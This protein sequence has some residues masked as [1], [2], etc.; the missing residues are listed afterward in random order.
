MRVPRH[1]LGERVMELLL[2]VI[3]TD[4]QFEEQE[5]VEIELVVRQSSGGRRA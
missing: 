3:E 5:E 2:K 1:K 4:G